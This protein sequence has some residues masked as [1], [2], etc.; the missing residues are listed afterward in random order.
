M[1]CVNCTVGGTGC[2]GLD[3]SSSSKTETQSLKG[4]CLFTSKYFL[5]ISQTN[6]M[7]PRIMIYSMAK[8]NKIKCL[9][10]HVR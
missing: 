6:K 7:A 3:N 10:C 8:M 1:T 5:V 9:N 4:K 2:T